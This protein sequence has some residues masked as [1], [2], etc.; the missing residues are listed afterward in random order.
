MTVNS[1]IILPGAKFN[2][3][4]IDGLSPLDVLNIKHIYR[5]GGHMQFFDCGAA[6]E[7]VGLVQ[8]MDDMNIKLN[9]TPLG[10]QYDDYS[11]ALIL[12][13][14]NLLIFKKTH[15]YKTW[16]AKHGSEGQF[17]ALS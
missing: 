5:F 7:Y 14:N 10:L 15:V 4:C 12:N 2:F 8:T 13:V 9:D 11:T 17:Q 1:V 3:F 16:F 6:N